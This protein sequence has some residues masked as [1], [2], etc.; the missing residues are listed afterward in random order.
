MDR[1][2]MVGSCAALLAVSGCAF[3]QI[4]PSAGAEVDADTFEVIDVAEYEVFPRFDIPVEQS[5]R[6]M[7]RLRSGEFV[8]QSVWG[9]DPVES[10]IDCG[11]D[12]EGMPEARNGRF[13]VEVELRVDERTRASA[14]GTRRRTEVR[15]DGDARRD[16]ATEDDERRCRLALPFRQRVVDAIASRFGGRRPGR[17]TLLAPP[18][19]GPIP[20]SDGT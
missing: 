18:I 7:G 1:V 16:A 2:T 8:V 15:L 14:A 6:S 20:P 12:R 19:G 4:G 5:Y 10:R 17:D 11:W 13:V 9:G 3:L